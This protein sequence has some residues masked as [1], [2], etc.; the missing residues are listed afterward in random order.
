VIKF[1]GHLTTALVE[2]LLL[3]LSQNEASLHNEG[4][5]QFHLLLSRIVSLAA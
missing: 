3:F 1:A 4:N 5:K 2:A